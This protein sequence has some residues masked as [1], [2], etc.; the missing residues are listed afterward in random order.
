MDQ[1]IVDA[2]VSGDAEKLRTLLELGGD[3][4]ERDARGRTALMWAATENRPDLT[5]ELLAAGAEPDA[6]D[7]RSG[8]TALWIAAH[9]GHWMVVRA[10]LLH[11]AS[12]RETALLLARKN[13]HQQASREIESLLTPD[14]VVA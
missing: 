9:L 11:G 5:G 1:S 4:N 13:G 14:R 12:H 2:V 10:L 8:I 3:P 6:G 7:P